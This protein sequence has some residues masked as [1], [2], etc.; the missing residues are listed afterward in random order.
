MYASKKEAV[1]GYAVMCCGDNWIW[2]FDDTGAVILCCSAL[3]GPAV[4][5]T[6]GQLESRKRCS[7]LPGFVE[8]G[9]E[10]L[11]AGPRTKTKK[12]KMRPTKK[13]G[14]IRNGQVK[15]DGS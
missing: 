1:N 13:P 8:E 15:G 12:K 10:L 6:C 7:P 2:F 3:F 11:M 9:E 5:G 14:T 4:I